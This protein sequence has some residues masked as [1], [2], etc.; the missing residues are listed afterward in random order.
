MAAAAEGLAQRGTLGYL[1]LT[2]CAGQRGRVAASAPWRLED[3]LR[4]RKQAHLSQPALARGGSWWVCLWL[5]CLPI[6]GAWKVRISPLLG[7]IP[8]QPLA[9]ARDFNLNT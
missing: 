5:G 7:E 3:F 4:S 9:G 6:P 1:F 8:S 2:G